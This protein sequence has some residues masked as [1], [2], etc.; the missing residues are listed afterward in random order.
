MSLLWGEVKQ[1]QA[2]LSL[3][4]DPVRIMRS[5]LSQL[6]RSLLALKAR[7][8]SP[9]TN[10][11]PPIS[12]MS[13]D[14]LNEWRSP[15]I[16]LQRGVSPFCTTSTPEVAYVRSE[17]DVAAVHSVDSWEAEGSDDLPRSLCADGNT[18]GSVPA[19]FYSGEDQTSAA[20]ELSTAQLQTRDGA[21]HC[22]A[23]STE[24]VSRAIETR[25]R[26]SMIL[27]LEQMER[28]CKEAVLHAQEKHDGELKAVNAQFSQLREAG[29]Q[30]GQELED[31]IRNLHVKSEK[32]V[33]ALSGSVT[34]LASQLEVLHALESTVEAVQ[35]D[36]GG[37][38]AELDVMSRDS[39]KLQLM[40]SKMIN[41]LQQV[42]DKVDHV[43]EPIHEHLAD[44]VSAMQHSLER[45]M[46]ELEQRVLGVTQGLQQEIGDTNERNKGTERRL[47]AGTKQLQE[48][49]ESVSEIEKQFRSTLEA[50][51]EV[52]SARLEVL[53]QVGVGLEHEVAELRDKYSR[54]EGNIGALL[55]ATKDLET[56]DEQVTRL[57]SQSYGNLAAVRELAERLEQAERQHVEFE[58][59]RQAMLEI[60]QQLSNVRRTVTYLETMQVSLRESVQN[61]NA[62]NLV[63]DA[64]VATPW[65]A[66][67]ED[68]IARLAAQVGAL[69]EASGSQQSAKGS[70]ARLL[71]RSHTA[72]AISQAQA[73]AVETTWD[74][75]AHLPSFAQLCR[76]LEEVCRPWHRQAMILLPISCLFE[77]LSSGLRHLKA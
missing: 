31:A 34:S 70:C 75:A 35:T 61:E 2:E 38:K 42:G 3:Y 48:S 12:P 39:A 29:R 21:T 72:A 45:D 19:E 60:V 23:R 13:P 36:V 46:K 14:V 44:T 43:Y 67:L 18:D 66:E 49:V 58:Q 55:D 27:S 68:S 30:H 7:I 25:I 76:Q 54:V 26:D 28:R 17:E 47:L 62:A 15:S 56:W 22:S 73:G 10:L 33:A 20:S 8:D 32:D 37:L 6:Q 51:Q 69:T 41:E 74:D 16:A 9:P 63:T 53:T 24:S 59:I 64:D 52:I 71:F 65:K 50:E 40:T 77:R 57:T 5:E 11:V 1:I 4:Q